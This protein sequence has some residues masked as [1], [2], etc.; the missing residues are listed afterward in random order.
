MK[1]DEAMQVCARVWGRGEGERLRGGKVREGM[2]MR[3][4]WR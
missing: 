4:K 2:K 1:E 3:G